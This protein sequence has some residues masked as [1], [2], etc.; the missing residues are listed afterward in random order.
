MLPKMQTLG[1][2]VCTGHRR[3][4]WT[5]AVGVTRC[6]DTRLDGLALQPINNGGLRKKNLLRL[7]SNYMLPADPALQHPACLDTPVLHATVHA[8]APQIPGTAAVQHHTL[9][10]DCTLEH[11]RVS[12]HTIRTKAIS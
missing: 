11:T 9:Y 5:Q 10:T 8:S 6:T 1:R 4:V 7:Y 12:H 3:H 2:N